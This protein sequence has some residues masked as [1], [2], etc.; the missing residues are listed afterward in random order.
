VA[1]GQGLDVFGRNRSV[2]RDRFGLF[3]CALLAGLI[4]GQ[5]PEGPGQRHRRRF[6]T[7][8]DEGEQI[9]H[10]SGVGIDERANGLNW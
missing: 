4:L 3:E 9:V 5:E 10:H 2:A 8:D 7:R 1:V 6:M